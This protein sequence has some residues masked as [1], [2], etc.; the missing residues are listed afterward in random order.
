MIFTLAVATQPRL[1]VTV[2]VLFPAQR[3]FAV[4]VVEGEAT[5]DAPLD[6]LYVKGEFNVPPMETVAV[7]LHPPK[8]NGGV[9]EVI[10]AVGAPVLDTLTVVVAVQPVLVVT[11]TM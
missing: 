3:L 8:H 5:V 9:F 1:S 6:Q 7:P 10:V 11:V 4:F 2:T